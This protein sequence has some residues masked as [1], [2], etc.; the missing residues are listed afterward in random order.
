MLCQYRWLNA[1]GANSLEWLS[2]LG[3]DSPTFRFSRHFFCCNFTKDYRKQKGRRFFSFL[4]TL[5]WLALSM[6]S[7][8]VLCVAPNYQWLRYQ[9]NI[10]TESIRT[11]FPHLLLCVTVP[12]PLLLVL[13][14]K[15][16]DTASFSFFFSSNI[17][18]YSSGSTFSNGITTKLNT[19]KPIM[20]P[21]GVLSQAMILKGLRCSK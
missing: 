10:D 15:R 19:M 20:R 5:K 12:V 17:C 1:R 18:W 21:Y 13:P 3:A 16:C 8:I 14:V 11:L 4:M 6:C 9:Y 7:V 2:G